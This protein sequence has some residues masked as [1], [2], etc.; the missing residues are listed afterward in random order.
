[1]D[2]T[3]DAPLDA[4]RVGP[5]LAQLEAARRGEVDADVPCHGCT[6]CCR[7]SQ[8]VPVGPDEVDTLAHLPAELLFPVPGR[9]GHLL[10]GY[11]ERGR[12]PML[13]EDGCAVYAHRPR[14]CR[15]YD[16]RTYAATGVAPDPA[17]QGD[18]AVR[19]GRWRFE[20]RDEED[21]ARLAALRAA[22]RWVDEHRSELPVAI[23]PATPSH[24]AALAVELHRAFA[25]GPDRPDPTELVAR[26]ADA[27]TPPSG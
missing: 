2:P 5:W 20:V 11:D 12:C 10:L 13:S 3:L 22:A 8:F 19:V 23:R 24:H 9:P 7:A 4:G 27:A 16:C 15:A 26:V 6:A 18:V 1:V 17:T 14:A 25:P 21:A